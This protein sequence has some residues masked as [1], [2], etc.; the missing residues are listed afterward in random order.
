MAAPGATKQGDTEKGF[1]SGDLSAHRAL[2][3]GEVFGSFGEAFVPR[4]G[5]EGNQGRSG[6]NFSSH[7]LG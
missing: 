4:C 2:R 5:L 3:Q 7:G 6:G 1:Q